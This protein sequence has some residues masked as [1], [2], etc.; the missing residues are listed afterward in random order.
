MIRIASRNVITMCPGF[1]CDLQTMDDLQKTAVIDREFHR[2]RIDIAA[3]QE[4]RLV[5]DGSLRERNYTFFWQGK[6]QTYQGSMA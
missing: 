3:L 4:T 1:H 6:R 5:D 2:L